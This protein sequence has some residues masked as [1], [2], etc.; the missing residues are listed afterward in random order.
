MREALKTIVKNAICFECNLPHSESGVD[1]SCL[2]SVKD[3]C[4]KNENPQDVA[5]VI[6]NGIVEFALGEYDIDYGNLEKEQLKVLKKNIRYNP[7]AKMAAKLKYGFYGEVLLDLVLRCLLK[8]SVVVAR[9]YFYSPIE[10]SE[11]KGFDAFHLIDSGEKLDLWFGEAKFYKS[12]NEAITPVLEKLSTSLSDQYVDRNLLAI[13][14]ERHNFTASNPKLNALL[15]EWEENPAINLARQM[16]KHQIRLTY[17]IFIA[18]EKKESHSFHESIGKCIEHILS[19]CTELNI[20]IPASFDYRL[21]F[22]FLPL[23][24][25]KRIKESVVEWIDSQEPLI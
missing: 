9:G 4:F 21:F 10:N 7:D 18:Y 12:Y 1:K 19:K 24:E 8:T 13:L 6:Y 2:S 14:N 25:V 3:V 17:P 5:K 22:M 16:K 15:D 20:Q 23:A 11:V